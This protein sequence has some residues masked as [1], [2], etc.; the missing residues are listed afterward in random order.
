MYNLSATDIGIAGLTVGVTTIIGVILIELKCYYK[1]NSKSP[2]GCGCTDTQML[3]SDDVQI[4]QTTING[5]DLIYV[6][7]RKSTSYDSEDDE[8]RSA[9]CFF[10]WYSIVF[11]LGQQISRQQVKVN[12]PI[13]QER[14]EP[15]HE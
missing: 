9:Y 5:V 7:K 6:S 10:G 8:R 13:V 2:C 12:H 4:N 1:M 15:V 11:M 14:K 3:D